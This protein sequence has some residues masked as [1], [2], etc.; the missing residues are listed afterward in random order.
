MVVIF[1]APYWVQFYLAVRVDDCCPVFVMASSCDSI[2]ASAFTIARC[3]WTVLDRTQLQLRDL[4]AELKNDIAEFWCHSSL[5]PHL[6]FVT[7]FDL[8]TLH[9]ARHSHWRDENDF[10]R[11]LLSLTCLC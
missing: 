3:L 6:T 8:S 10:S 5:S 2:T 11:N 1:G 7:T 4:F 9:I